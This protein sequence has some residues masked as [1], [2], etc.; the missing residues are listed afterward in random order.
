MTSVFKEKVCP[1]CIVM[2]T[3]VTALGL[4]QVDTTVLGLSPEDAEK[5]PY[6]AS[7]GIY[8]FK[9]EVLLKLLRYN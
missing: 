3:N 5:K 1:F 7:M 9:E 4:Q 6:I 8:V 2:L